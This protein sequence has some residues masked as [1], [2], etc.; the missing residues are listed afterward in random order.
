MATGELPLSATVRLVGGPEVLPRLLHA[1][2][3]GDPL[4]KWRR[5]FVAPDFPTRSTMKYLVA[6]LM[7]PASRSVC[8]RGAAGVAFRDFSTKSLSAAEIKAAGFGDFFAND[9]TART[10]LPAGEGVHPAGVVVATG[11]NPTEERAGQF[12][13]NET[14]LRKK[15]VALVPGKAFV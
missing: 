7:E 8:G 13:S 9:S 10:W 15:S 11:D 4:G 1:R 5:E 2:G 3:Q 6:S 14:L 12:G